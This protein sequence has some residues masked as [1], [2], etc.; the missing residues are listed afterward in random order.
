VVTE[1]ETRVE[2]FELDG[3]PVGDVRT[4]RAF[5]A[6]GNVTE[7]LVEL[8]EGYSQRTATTWRN[9]AARWLLGLA[10]RVE[11][12][13]NAP[14]YPSTT[15]VVEQ[16]HDPERGLLVQS[17]ADPD[18]P[19]HRVQTDLA[20]DAFGNALTR[21]TTGPD[22]A[23]RTTAMVF[24]P[25][26]QFPVME[27]DA[28]GHA[29]VRAIDPR[30]GVPLSLQGPD[31]SLPAATLAYDALGRVA[32]STRSD[33]IATVTSREVCAADC[34]ALAAIS[35]RTE[36]P[37]RPASTSWF[38]ALGREIRTESAGF[39]GRAVRVDT[40]WD[41]RG[42][43][44]S[45]TRPY[46]AG[47]GPHMAVYEHDALG[48]IIRSTLPDGAQ[49][50]WIRGGR[51]LTVVDPLGR[52]RTETRNARGDLIETID[53]LGAHASLPTRQ[54]ARPVRDPSGNETRFAYDAAGRQIRATTGS[55]HLELRVRA[56]GSSGHSLDARGDHALRLGRARTRRSAARATAQAARWIW[57]TAE[58]G[59][60][61]ARAHGGAGP[62]LRAR[63]LLRRLRAPDHHDHDLG[64]HSLRVQRSYDAL[65]GRPA[66]LPTASRSATATPPRV[67]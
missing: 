61:S 19:E 41:A 39:D 64:A 7:E 58:H 43:V 2:R 22:F 29:R 16:R 54:E 51:S 59:V 23:P 14:S 9:D 18:L 36:T 27:L 53:A 30:F 45:R 42:N 25:R 21:L 38:D 63:A 12:T 26:G 62:G 17:A 46:Y 55:R 28:L 24:D 5:D 6:F 3:E 15:R 31:M 48:R 4:T 1:V 56:S 11:L 8:G 44:A 57:D 66:A 52:A 35:L 50:Q 20:Y 32:S 13:S 47:E 67:T 40:A 37:G 49:T 10:E 60:E 34:P 65:A 33:G